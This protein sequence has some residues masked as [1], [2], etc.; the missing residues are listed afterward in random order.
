MNYYYCCYYYH[1]HYY[2]YYCSSRDNKDGTR[3][4]HGLDGPA[5]ESRWGE[6]FLTRPDLPWGPLSLL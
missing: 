4:C 2:Y 5:I 3:T 1:H 6:I